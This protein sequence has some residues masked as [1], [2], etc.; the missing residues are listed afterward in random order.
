MLIASYIVNYEF[1]SNSMDNHQGRI[2]DLVMGG[3]DFYS[4]EARKIFWTRPPHS[5]LRPPHMGGRG[6]LWGGQKQQKC[7]QEA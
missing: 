5:Q 7:P 6:W 1:E 4:R 2:Q 3:A